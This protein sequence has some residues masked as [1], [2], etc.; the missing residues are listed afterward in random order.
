[1]D[2][3]DDDLYGDL[4]LTI[5]KKESKVGGTEHNNNKR[6]T[7]GGSGRGNHLP[8]PP[9]YDSPSNLHESGSPFVS[10][11]IRGENESL[12]KTIKILQDENLRLKRNIGTLFR[13]AKNEIK[14][15]DDHIE[16]LQRQQDDRN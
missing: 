2:S 3:N 5:D 16:R 11:R 15:K 6:K 12:K 1:M 8:P 4:D 14:R 7:D 13:T 9:R 10:S